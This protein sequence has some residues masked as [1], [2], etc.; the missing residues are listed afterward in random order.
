MQPLSSPSDTVLSLVTANA[1]VG[2]VSI[3]VPGYELLDK[4]GEGGMGTVFRAMQLSLNR[5]VAVKVLHAASGCGDSLPAFYRESRLLAS[6]S[7]PHIV[8]IHD[9]G[10]HEGR[11]FLVTEYVSGSPLREAMR[12]GKPWPIDRTAETLDRIAQALIYIH[13]HGVLHLDLKPENVLCTPDGNIKIADFGLALARVDARLLSDL[14]LAQGTLDYCPP[15]QRYGLRTDERSDLFS[16]GVLAY[17][18]LTGHLPGRIYQSAVRLNR[19]LPVAVDDLLRRALA[20]QPDERFVSVAEFN[21]QLQAVLRPMRPVEKRKLPL[22]LLGASLLLLLLV[23]YP[24]G[25]FQRAVTRFLVPTTPAAPAETPLTKSWLL[26][27]D[28]ES[29]RWFGELGRCESP[30]AWT[31]ELKRLRPSGR[32]PD[33]AEDPALPEWPRPRP[34]LMLQ[35]PNEVVF[36]HPVLNPRLAAWAGEHWK[37]VIDSPIRPE[38]NFVRNGDF[39]E[40]TDFGAEA[41][42]WRSYWA[43]G[44]GDAIRIGVPADRFENP[45]LHLVKQ[46]SNKQ[47]ESLGLYQWLARTPDRPGEIVVLRFRA[48]AERGD[49]RLLLGPR[50]PVVIP[51][52]DRGPDAERLRALTAPH[53][54]LPVREGEEVREYR[55][56]DWVQPGTDWR[57]YAIIWDWP[58]CTTELNHRNIEIRF[59]GLGGVWVDDIEVFTWGQGLPGEK[60]EQE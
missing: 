25:P 27:D 49:G 32:Y 6:L 8:T 7:H 35:S 33:A 17:E 2:D 40:K 22:A 5:V 58:Q 24:G 18:L 15:E 16:L 54:F 53:R 30:P 36:V 3:V 41:N 42:D 31:I 13:Q 14:G 57:S 59:A 39:A 9:C 47:G 44:D 50:L 4:A 56:M 55:P 34:V 48:R 38:D 10:Q 19:R 21:R 28:P 26:Y 51:R 60:A 20:R 29:L 1:S 43:A 45:A 37:Q 46:N 12:P 23:L 52:D 11:Y